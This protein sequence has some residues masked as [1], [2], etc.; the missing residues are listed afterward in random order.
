MDRATYLT[1]IIVAIAALPPGAAAKNPHIANNEALARLDDIDTKLDELGTRLAQIQQGGVGRCTR[2]QRDAGNCTQVRATSVNVCFDLEIL[3]AELV[4]D[5]KF[6]VRAT[7]EGG[8]GWTSGPDGKIMVTYF[9]PLGPVPS[10]LGIDLKAPGVKL[11]T[12]VCMEFPI[13]VLGAV[14]ARTAPATAADARATALSPEELDALQTRLEDALGTVLP[15]ALDRIATAL[16]SGPDLERGLATFEDIGDGNFDLQRGV[17]EQ[18]IRDVVASLPTPKLAR[19]MA[20]DPGSF[21]NYLSSLDGDGTVGGRAAALCSPDSGLSI[22]RSPLFAERTAELC[23][24]LGS[25]PQFDDI[26]EAIPLTADEVVD[27]VT[28]LLDP[29]LAN[30]GSGETVSQARSRFCGTAVGMRRAFDRLCGR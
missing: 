23:S 14:S 3:S 30:T 18:P 29:V 15:R 25:L 24:Y 19:D 21:A 26:A 6:K 17:L 8:I 5:Y 27:A 11:D 4:W 16:P 1:W 9:G 22:T 7:G 13:D 28:E 10:E 20:V 12:Q 2:A